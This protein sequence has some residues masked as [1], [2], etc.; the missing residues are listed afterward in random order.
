VILGLLRTQP[1][2]YVLFAEATK[3]YPQFGQTID[4]LAANDLLRTRIQ[5]SATHLQELLYFH[6]KVCRIEIQDLQLS[7]YLNNLDWSEFAKRAGFQLSGRQGERFRSD[8]TGLGHPLGELRTIPARI[9]LKE[10]AQQPG[11]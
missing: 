8:A 3:Q 1:D 2:H 9:R 6:P 10:L 7:F 11:Q 5:S 4:W